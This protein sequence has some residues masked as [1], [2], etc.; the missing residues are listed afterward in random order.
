MTKYKVFLCVFTF[1]LSLNLSGQDFKLSVVGGF[2]NLDVNSKVDGEEF[3]LNDISS[4]GFYIGAQTEIS[5]TEKIDLQPEL[6]LGIVED[7]NALYLGVLGKYNFSEK[8]SLLFGPSFNYVLEEFA[9]DYQNFGIAVAVGVGYDISD[10]FFA[11][12]KFNFQINNYYNGNSNI[13]SRANFFLLG[14]GYRVL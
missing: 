12:A 7:S 5:L 6:V 2:L 10:K 13:T 11:Q 3:D 14:V 9:E 4:T 1:I 8:F